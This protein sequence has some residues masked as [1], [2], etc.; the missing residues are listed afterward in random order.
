VLHGKVGAL[1]PKRG[2]LELLLGSPAARLTHGP[3]GFASPSHGGFAIIENDISS[4]VRLTRYLLAPNANDHRIL[5]CA[6]VFVNSVEARL[7]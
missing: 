1:W 7:S 6:A 2:L 4:L 3:G 5:F